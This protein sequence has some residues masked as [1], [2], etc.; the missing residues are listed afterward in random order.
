MVKRARIQTKANINDHFSANIMVNFA[1]FSG[2]PTNKVLEN[3][4][5]RYTL[6]KHFNVQAG[7]FRPFFGIEDAMPVDII[8][9]LDYSN[10]YY[11]FGSNGWQSFQ[12]GMSIFGDV[13]GPLR[14]YAGVYNGNN[15]N[16][17]SDDD[18]TKNMYGRLETDLGT[19]F[20]IGINAA[21]GSQ[22][23]SGTGSAWGGDF[24][25]KIPLADKWSVSLS[26][27]YKNGSHFAH[28]NAS[29][30]NP[31][32][33]LNEFRMQGFYVF[34]ILRYEWHRPRV[35]AIEFSS[36]YEY[37]DE[38]YKQAGNVRQT[39]IPNF[40]LVFADNFYVAVQLGMSLDFFERDIPLTT[41]Y[42]RQ[43]GY[44]QLQIRF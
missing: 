10:Q 23:G 16:Q 32:P 4:Y 18:D 12:I 33:D 15:R 8:R 5:V 13:T 38:D 24:L 1:E 36:R 3:A 28:Y 34:P 42:T 25:A 27:E 2:N 9:T 41:T 39:V 6:N 29:T 26:G 22:A 31:K 20:T 44:A 11:A 35:R 37:F 7:E 19:N 40:N 43:L 21:L 30:L 17:P 14:Y